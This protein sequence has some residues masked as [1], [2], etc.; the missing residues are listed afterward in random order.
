M[1]SY[2]KSC[3]NYSSFNEDSEDLVRSQLCTCRDSSAVVTCAKLWSDLLNILTF[4]Q[5]ILLDVDYELII[6]CE[7]GPE[8]TIA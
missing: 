7:T 1:S 5:H 6:V 8:D 2:L 4:E 3:E